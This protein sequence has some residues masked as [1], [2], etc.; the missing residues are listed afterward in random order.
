MTPCGKCAATIK[1][2]RETYANRI[3]PYPYSDKMARL[4]LSINVND[5]IVRRAIVPRKVIGQW[6]ATI[7]DSP[8]VD[9]R[10]GLDG[11]GVIPTNIP[12]NKMLVCTKCLL[13]ET[14]RLDSYNCDESFQHLTL[15]ENLELQKQVK[16]SRAM[17][18][19]QGAMH[20]EEKKSTKKKEDDS[21]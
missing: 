8:D 5:E 17:L 4:G 9:I 2:Q 3:V 19:E 14:E 1:Q 21:E 13:A 18:I 12:D 11:Y 20:I 10:C 7:L 16:K 15:E 6:E